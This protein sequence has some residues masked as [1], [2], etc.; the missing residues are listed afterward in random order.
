MVSLVRITLEDGFTHVLGVEIAR[1]DSQFGKNCPEDGFTHRLR[2]EIAVQD[3]Q[4]GKNSSE[5]GLTH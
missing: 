1:Q 3:G 4:F 5:D 2:V